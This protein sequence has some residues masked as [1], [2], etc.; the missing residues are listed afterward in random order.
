MNA[1]VLKT[2]V[3]SR[4]PWVRILPPPNYFYTL[5]D[6]QYPMLDKIG[7]IL[8][9]TP[10]AGGDINQVYKIESTKGQFV[11]K[12]NANSPPDMFATEA[13]GLKLLSQNGLTVPRVVFYKDD[14]LLMEYIEP[15]YPDFKKAGEDLGKLHAISQESFGLEYDNFIG[16]L[17]QI[18]KVSADW[19]SF[20]WE[21]RIQSQLDLYQNKSK[22]EIWEKLR[23]KLPG[24]LPQEIRPSLIHGDLWSGNLIWGHNSPYF[25]DP[26]VYRA[27]PMIELAFTRLFGGFHKNFYEAYSYHYP[28]PTWYKDLLPLYQI[29]PLL[30]HANHF[31]GGYYQSALQ[32]AEYYL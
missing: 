13:R 16:R 8:S 23:D 1:A 10:L 19:C 21:Q 20:F 14:Q 18:N 5:P 2:V 22:E 17:R 29:Y 28:I 11:L 6:S 32:N 24:I 9:R 12:E 4:V 27:D 3:P 7:K 25:I 15:G 30:V 26:A 31:G